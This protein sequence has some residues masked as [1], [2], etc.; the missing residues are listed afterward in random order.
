MDLERFYARHARI[1]DATRFYLFDRERAIEALDVRRG[2]RV[3][4]FACG[5][6]MNF[7]YLSRRGA[8]IV[9][10][11]ASEAM[12]ERARRRAP[13]AELHHADVTAFD[14]GPADRVLCT[15][16][17][18]M[19]AAWEDAL[20][21][22]AATLGPDGRLVVLDFDTFTGAAAWLAPAQRAW[23][24]GFAVALSLPVEEVLAAHFHDVRRESR[25]A[26]WNFLVRAARPKRPRGAGASS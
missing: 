2:D 4:D 10:V 21:V 8:R 11:D 5:T 7:P 24:R 19:V 15:Y 12:L 14:P 23:F 9:G 6:G 18:S 17:L 25:H 1:Y 26:G 3:V 13:G 16:S 20:A 22:M